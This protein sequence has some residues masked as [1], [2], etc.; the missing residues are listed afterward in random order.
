MTPA[1]RRAF[2]LA[3]GTCAGEWWGEGRAEFQ[4]RADAIQAIHGVA[5]ALG[6]SPRLLFWVAR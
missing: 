1:Q 3:V 4:T 2:V 5:M 6:I